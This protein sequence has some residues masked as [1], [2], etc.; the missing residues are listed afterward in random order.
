MIWK[1]HGPGGDLEAGDVTTMNVSAEEAKDPEMGNEP[2]FAAG[3]ISLLCWKSSFHSSSALAAALPW[4]LSSSS[5]EWSLASETDLKVEL[6]G[7]AV[8][9]A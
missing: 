2:V 7:S 4:R 8:L 9:P 5:E 6:C 3:M 1:E